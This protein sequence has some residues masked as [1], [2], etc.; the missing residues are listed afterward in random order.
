MLKKISLFFV[1]LILP[2]ATQAS[3]GFYVGAAGG[4]NF[5]HKS[6]TRS[7]LNFDEGYS[8]T[9]TG[10]YGFFDVF[11]AEVEGTFHR[12]NIR[13][14]RFL[15]GTFH[16]G[17]ARSYA[18]MGNLIY[19]LYLGNQFVPYVG[20]GI[21]CEANRLVISAPRHRSFTNRR[22]FTRQLIL[23]I[24]YPLCCLVDVSI[25]YKLRRGVCHNLTQT[26]SLGIKRFF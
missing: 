9:L 26:L 3:E 12:N 4:V 18:V 11:R 13:S 7:H 22:G 20:F 23:G 5:L 8:A 16:C 1:M 17:H 10:G 21:G 2:L 15:D 14:I 6:H 25:D 19:D 24:S